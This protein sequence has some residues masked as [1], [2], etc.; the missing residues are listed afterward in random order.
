M[1]PNNKP[2]RR[3]AKRK[4]DPGSD[5]AERGRKRAQN[6][7]SQ[8]CL[9]EKNLAHVRSLEET[10]ALLQQAVASG[11]QGS[12]Y[13]NLLETHLKLM[14]ENRRLQDALLRL[15]KKLLSLSNAASAAADDEVFDTVLGGSQ[16]TATP[17]ADE[18]GHGDS[19]GSP[20]AEVEPL[21]HQ[22]PNTEPDTGSTTAQTQRAADPGASKLQLLRNDPLESYSDFLNVCTSTW[23]LNEHD[24]AGLTMPLPTWMLSHDHIVITSITLFGSK[25][26]D[27]CD[28]Y[29]KRKSTS[30]LPNQVDE[31]NQKLVRVAIEFGTRCMGLGS[32]V[33]GVNGARYM[34]K[35]LSWRLGL[36]PKDKVPAPFRPTPLQSREP[37]HFWGLDLFNWPELRDQ[38]VLDHELVDL[39][40]LTKDLVLNSVV[41][42]PQRGVA[43]N[44]L[45][46]FEN[47]ILRRDKS[48][49]AQSGTGRNY[50][51]DASWV[52]F[53]VD[54]EIQSLYGSMA[55]PVEEAIIAELDQRM[56]NEEATPRSCSKGSLPS[57]ESYPGTDVA[58]FLGIDNFLGWK[59]SQEFAS[60]YPFLDCS[61]AIS[62]YQLA[63][64]EGFFYW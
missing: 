31:W 21:G 47:Q 44:V 42:Q 25:L 41:E 4:A 20:L 51:T 27:A 58:H 7:I 9:R 62:D 26:L 56:L 50:L 13:A 5:G 57:P 12:R 18:R 43:V 37:T 64:S 54:P 39:D 55:D 34:E 10:V 17:P 19:P 23:P 30:T 52:L 60:K 45:D 6:R 15:R 32:Y 48:G 3:P 36:E 49:Y 53:E 11:D 61:T 16:D 35:V 38:L 46:I 59:I 28:K 33:Y 1:P 29:I 22:S 8:Q 14:E 24:E 63:P 2:S 40:T